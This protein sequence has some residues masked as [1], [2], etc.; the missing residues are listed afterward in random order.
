M[1]AINL[2]KF[3]ILEIEHKQVKRRTVQS[4]LSSER[5]SAWNHTALVIHVDVHF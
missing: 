2:R 1:L 3:S 4:S 5:N